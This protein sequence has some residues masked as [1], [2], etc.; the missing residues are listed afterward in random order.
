MSQEILKLVEKSSLKAEVPQFAVGDTVE[1][2]MTGNVVS[3]TLTIS[4][5][6]STKSWPFTGAV[7]AGRTNARTGRASTVGTYGYS[8]HLL[9]RQ[10][11][12]GSQRVVIDPDIIIE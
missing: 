10:P 11:G 1:W 12:G 5:K 2:Q 3:D 8:V 7:P 4:L 9:C 6:D